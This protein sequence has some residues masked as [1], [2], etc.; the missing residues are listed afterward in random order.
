MNRAWLVLL[1]VA[2]ACGGEDHG[3]PA[4]APVVADGGATGTGGAGG[5]APV[6]TKRTVIQRNPFGNVA[7]ADNLLWDGDFEWRSPFADQ[8][9]WLSGG[10]N[11]LSYALPALALAEACHSG[12]K[13]AS[14]PPGNQIVGLALGSRDAALAVSFWARRESGGCGDDVLAVVTDFEGGPQYEVPPP[15]SS[16]AGGWCRFSA[17]VTGSGGAPLLL[18]RNV[19]SEKLVVDDAVIAPISTEGATLVPAPTTSL[20]E[21]DAIVAAAK[22]AIEP[23]RPPPSAAQEALEAY[24]TRRMRGRR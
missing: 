1:L 23:R 21:M 11:F 16:E 20:P 14:I 15:A 22:K 2:V 8:Y 7:Q 24:L 19:G 13:C 6:P 3:G 18:I 10:S 17:L 12:L 9:G 4:P 5:Q